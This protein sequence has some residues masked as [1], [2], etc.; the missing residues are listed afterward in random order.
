MC[1]VEYASGYF[2]PAG[3]KQQMEPLTTEQEVALTSDDQTAKVDQIRNETSVMLP[4]NQSKID[5]SNSEFQTGIN[6][7]LF[8]HTE[9]TEDSPGSGLDNIHH[10]ETSLIENTKS[11]GNDVD[12]NHISQ[13]DLQI[14]TDV[15]GIPVP[16][17]SSPIS[18][19]F[20]LRDDVDSSLDAS[21]FKDSHN[22]MSSD[23]P[24]SNIK[25]DPNQ[26]TANHVDLLSL[27][28]DSTTHI[29][30][31]PEGN[32]SYVDRP[33]DFSSEFEGQLQSKPPTSNLIDSDDIVDSPDSTAERVDAASAALIKKD[34]EHNDMLQLPAEASTLNPSVHD[35]LK[36][37][38]SVTISGSDFDQNEATMLPRESISSTEGHILDD[39]ALSVAYSAEVLV[40]PSGNEP[41]ISSISQIGRSSTPE[42]A[43]PEKPIS[44]AGIPA[45][46]LVPAALQVPPGKVLVPAVDDQVQC[47]ALAALQVLKVPIYTY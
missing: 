42:S 47:Q 9:I 12:A 22:A 28:A 32:L 16:S 2:V 19:E 3:V 27:S 26:S 44:Y 20:S 33:L 29:N 41:D 25:H 24:D 6:K 39:N 5:D 37:V 17:T 15:D 18:P 1:S 10:S 38:S 7:D 46:S 30:D 36:I 43:V 14:G 31:H 40:D 13:D 23:S 11:N 34:F 45:P 8:S 21:H 35:I 4:D